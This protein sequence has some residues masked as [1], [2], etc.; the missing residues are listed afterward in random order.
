M[1]RTLNQV[2]RQADK[3]IYVKKKKKKK[4]QHCH[5]DAVDVLMVCYFMTQV[6]QKPFGNAAIINN[7]ISHNSAFPHVGLIN[8]GYY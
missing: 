2:H 1:E 5:T 8:L 3:I 7:C 4:K 6:C